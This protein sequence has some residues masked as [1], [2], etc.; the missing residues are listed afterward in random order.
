MTYINDGNPSFVE[1][2]SS[3]EPHINFSKITLFGSFIDKWRVFQQVPYTTLKADNKIIAWIAN[4]AAFVPDMSGL[5]QNDEA[6]AQ[7]PSDAR[8]ARKGSALFRKL[9][10]TMSRRSRPSSRCAFFFFFLLCV[11][12]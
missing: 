12:H 7:S 4:M 2:P 9:H 10:E 6:N 1:V 5:L 11:G 8:N 3:Q